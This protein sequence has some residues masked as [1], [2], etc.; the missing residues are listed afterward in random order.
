LLTNIDGTP[1]DA[2]LNAVRDNA[3]ATRLQGR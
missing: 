2:A 1:L 3:A